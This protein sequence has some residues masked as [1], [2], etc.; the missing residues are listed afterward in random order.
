MLV[1]KNMPLLWLTTSWV[2]TSICMTTPEAI[3][4][5]NM[6]NQVDITEENRENRLCYLTS[7]CTP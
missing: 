4:T 3:Q 6:N 1:V 5:I 7:R 2:S